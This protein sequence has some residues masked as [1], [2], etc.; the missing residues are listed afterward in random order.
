MGSADACSFVVAECR[1]EL[2]LQQHHSASLFYCRTPRHCL[3]KVALLLPLQDGNSA[4]V[5]VV[6]HEQVMNTQ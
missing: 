1:S 6:C 5:G 2:L 4:H 3:Q